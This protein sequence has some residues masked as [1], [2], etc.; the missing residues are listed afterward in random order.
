MSEIPRP[1]TEEQERALRRALG[2]A[3]AVEIVMVVAAS[4]FVR[5]EGRRAMELEHTHFL[6]GGRAIR[7]AQD[8]RKLF[9]AD[10]LV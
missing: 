4:H 6:P 9:V 7:Y 5:I 10:V 2:G 3:S 1:L 8:G